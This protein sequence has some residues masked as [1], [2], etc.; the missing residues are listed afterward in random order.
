MSWV[1]LMCPMGWPTVVTAR[2]LTAPAPRH[3]LPLPST[4][5]YVLLRE[6]AECLLLLVH[7]SRANQK[8]LLAHVD[9]GGAQEQGRGGGEPEGMAQRLFGRLLRTCGDYLM[10]V[11]ALPVPPCKR[12]CPCSHI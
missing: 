7:R 2:F 4:T 1:H 10:Q 6:A 8:K 3:P 5:P 9:A 11:G 12:C